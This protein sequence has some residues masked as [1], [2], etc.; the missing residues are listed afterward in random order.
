MHNKRIGHSLLPLNFGSIQTF[1]SADTLGQYVQVFYLNFRYSREL[2]LFCFVLE[3]GLVE[4][5]E[6]LLGI[7]LRTRETQ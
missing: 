4:L 5:R 3:A 6:I 7:M 2:F 1:S